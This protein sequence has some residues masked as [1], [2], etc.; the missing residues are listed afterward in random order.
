ME[1]KELAHL[2]K[3]RMKKKDRPILVKLDQLEHNVI[4]RKADKYTNGNMS[5]WIRYASLNLEPREEDLTTLP[6]P[7]VAAV[8]EI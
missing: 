8:A 4:K 2:V 3:N 5:E 1:K 6:T 7:E